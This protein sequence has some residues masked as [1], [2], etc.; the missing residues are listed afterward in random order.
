MSLT[1]PEPTSNEPQ[2][3]YRSIP[4]DQLEIGHWN[5]RRREI[6]ADLDELAYSMQ[7][8]GLQHPIVV[9]PKNGKFE[10][11]IGQRT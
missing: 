2:G 1:R 11:I 8:F 7:A 9:Q 6:T 10:I 3:E 5:V 4:L